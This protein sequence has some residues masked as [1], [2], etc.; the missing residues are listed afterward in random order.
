M[1]SISGLL[2]S[3]PHAW[4]LQASR[5]V[6]C[7]VVQSR[8]SSEQSLTQP[9]S[10]V[11]IAH[12]LIALQRSVHVAVIAGLVGGASGGASTAASTIFASM[13]GAASGCGGIE[14]LPS[15]PHAANT[16]AIK[17]P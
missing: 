12:T 4:L 16:I 5:S 6:T 9:G 13:P 2:V 8:R 3:S 1:Q 10:G 7:C 17:A 14:L 15:S 11:S